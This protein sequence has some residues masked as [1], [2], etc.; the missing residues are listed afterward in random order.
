MRET[1]N[2]HRN[3]AYILCIAYIYEYLQLFFIQ[4][5]FNLTLW[6]V[7]IIIIVVTKLFFISLPIWFCD[8]E[9]IRMLLDL[10]HWFVRIQKPQIRW[11]IGT[12]LPFARYSH[13]Y[14]VCKLCA[15]AT[16]HI[17][18]VVT[19]TRSMGP[20]NDVHYAWLRV[21]YPVCIVD[22]LAQSTFTVRIDH[23]LHALPRLTRLSR[24][25]LHSNAWG[26]VCVCVVFVALATCNVH[27]RDFEP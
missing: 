26:C 23:E 22:A 20:W 19:H 7:I 10:L 8:N 14:S 2:I 16:P 21:E 6:M 13:M 17:I 15:S 24:E 4:T 25:C 3:H 11:P 18:I 5:E 1:E 9:Y 12:I 27:S